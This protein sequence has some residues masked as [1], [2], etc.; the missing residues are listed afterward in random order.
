MAYKSR[1]YKEPTNPVGT[2]AEL[3]AGVGGFRIGLAEA[4]W[5]TVY[6]NQWEPSTKTQHASNVMSLD[7]A[8][9]D[10]AMRTLLKLKNCQRKL[11]YWLVVFLVRIIQLQ[12]HSTLQKD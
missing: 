11:I 6:S 3:F 7:S 5:K 12:K 2:V 1:K 10:T 8:K 9:K 4:G